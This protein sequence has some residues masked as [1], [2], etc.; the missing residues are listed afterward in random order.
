MDLNLRYQPRKVSTLKKKTVI[1][2]FNL[3][4]TTEGNKTDQ[5]LCHLQNFYVN[6]RGIEGTGRGMQTSLLWSWKIVLS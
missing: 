4:Y 2:S 3:L 1:W 5:Q 6:F